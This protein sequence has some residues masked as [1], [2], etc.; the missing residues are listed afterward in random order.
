ME[1]GAVRIGGF[2]LYPNVCSLFWAPIDARRRRT[3]LLAGRRE[4]T[5]CR[6]STCG[7]VLVL[8]G[9]SSATGARGASRRRLAAIGIAVALVAFVLMAGAIQLGA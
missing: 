8:A 5:A 7:A 4:M 2:G 3:Q 6:C 9:T 1:P